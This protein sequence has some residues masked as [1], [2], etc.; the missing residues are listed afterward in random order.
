MLQIKQNTVNGKAVS[1]NTAAAI[2]ALKEERRTTFASVGSVG[3]AKR[4]E[5]LK[6]SQVR[7]GKGEQRC[8]LIF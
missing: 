6:L 8:L 3:T 1:N 7:K 5:H 2:E 4:Q